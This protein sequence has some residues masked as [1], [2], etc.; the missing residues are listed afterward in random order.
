MIDPTTGTVTD[1]EETFVVSHVFDFVSYLETEKA[2]VAEDILLMT[3]YQTGF[4]VSVSI[5][6]G[7][8][9]SADFQEYDV[10]FNRSNKRAPR[11]EQRAFRATRWTDGRMIVECLE[12]QR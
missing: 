1:L 8:E 2:P 4:T 6:A 9:A 3:V 7:D 5:R 11:M 12:P 10:V